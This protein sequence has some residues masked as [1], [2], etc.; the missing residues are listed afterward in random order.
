MLR[1]DTFGIRLYQDVFGSAAAYSS[2]KDVVLAENNGDV[3][4]TGNLI[5]NVIGNITGNLSG[6]VNGNVNGNIIFQSK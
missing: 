1:K 5:G 2:Y 3:I 6:T 4:L